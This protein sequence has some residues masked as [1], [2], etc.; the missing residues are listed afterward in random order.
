MK[1]SLKNIL[2]TPFLFWILVSLFGAYFIY[3]LK[4]NLKLGIDLVGGTYMTLQVQTDQVVQE[5]LQQRMHSIIKRLKDLNKE[6]PV[7]AK[8]ADD[9][10]IMVFASLNAAQSSEIITR[11]MY[12]GF[13]F[14]PVD[15][16]F[17][18]KASLREN[19]II[20][21][22]RMAV[23]S[24]V[25]VIRARLGV[26]GEAPVT[27]K[28]ADQI[29]IELPNVDNPQQAKAM[30]GRA[31]VLEIKPVLAS[32][33]SK[34]DILDQFDGDLPDETIII[35]A[36][37]ENTYYLVPSYVELKGSML[38]RAQADFD[39]RE[40]KNF[41]AI[42]FDS[43]GAE[44]FYEFTAEASKK[45]RPQNEIAIILD[46]EV[47]SAPVPQGPI[48]GGSAQISGNF[49]SDSAKELA[50]LL[51]SGSFSA[52]V[53]FEEDRTIAPTLGVESIRSGLISCLVSLI[54]LLI[55]SI[56]YYKVAGFFAFLTLLFNLLLILM[57][58]AY[59]NATLTLPGIAG[60]VLT[61]GMAIDASILIYESI[62]EELSKGVGLK[63]AIEVGFS[64][65]TVVILDSNIT[66]FIVGVV[67]YMLGTGPLQGFAVTMMLGIVSTLIT[68]LFFLK[69]LFSW[70]L[71]GF[72][73]QNL[74][75]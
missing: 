64:D 16:D 3:T 22:K 42:T 63:E 14:K 31:A 59:M 62:R 9:E 12:P 54:L 13:I 69:S 10:I 56:L 6:A 25:D 74:K 67:L 23:A 33:S 43:V 47:L 44:K 21:M 24:D 1:T 28:G 26:L 52:A 66:T 58:L 34:D 46:N 41:V 60:M 37:K 68:T 65:A 18:I 15:E 38:T 40:M 8:V 71:D 30:I 7:S 27:P 75:F 73:L 35:K 19:E 2:W 49:T 61:V 70:I 50:T 45:T 51:K 20:E 57:G 32:A 39:Q 48:A 5:N 36:L 29:T 72:G 55:F 11:E 53:T 17:T 4:D